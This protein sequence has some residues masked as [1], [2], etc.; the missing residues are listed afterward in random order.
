MRRKLFNLATAISVLLSLLIVLLWYRS[1]TWR[2]HIVYS[3]DHWNV[4]IYHLRG[5]VSFGLINEG[6]QPP[7]MRFAELVKGND[8][9]L[10][11]YCEHQ[12]FGVG[13]TWWAQVTRVRGSRLV[14]PYWLILL[15]FL[16]LPLRAVQ[17]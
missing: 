16:L 12:F 17:C 14:L 4:Q 9:A 5:N 8:Y 7:F 10:P 1:H 3:R 2:D 13:W 15:P 11:S 6:L